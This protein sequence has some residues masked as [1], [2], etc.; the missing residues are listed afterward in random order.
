[1]HSVEEFQEGHMY[2]YV[3]TVYQAG[4]TSAGGREGRTTAPLPLSLYAPSAM[5]LVS[6][7]THAVISIVML[8]VCVCHFK[9]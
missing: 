7:L 2:L 4:K 8:H 5:K 9:S 1:M 6:C 3:Y